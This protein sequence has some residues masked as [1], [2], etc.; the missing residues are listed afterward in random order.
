MSE[1]GKAM[2]L[3]K[4]ETEMTAS[5][6]R[7]NFEH[8]AESRSMEHEVEGCRQLPS[9]LP[10]PYSDVSAGE[11]Q[12]SQTPKNSVG[13]DATDTKYDVNGRCEPLILY[14]APLDPEI[15]NR[16]WQWSK[17]FPTNRRKVAQHV[18]KVVTILVSISFILHVSI[19][20]HNVCALL[21]L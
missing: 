15:P 13:S 4:E 21:P 5:T 17:Y 7:N 10:P 20:H 11:A 12:T 18:L 2:E 8:I 19:Q 3:N 1:T 9:S 14:T 16:R 6:Q